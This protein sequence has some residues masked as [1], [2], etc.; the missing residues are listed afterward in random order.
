MVDFAERL[1]DLKAMHMANRIRAINMIGPQVEGLTFEGFPT[2]KENQDALQHVGAWAA[3]PDPPKKGL[4]IFGRPGSGKTGLMV[5]ALRC[6]AERKDGDA[7][8]WVLTAGGCTD[9]QVQ[10]QAEIFGLQH[11]G[12][13]RR[14]PAPVCADSWPLLERRLKMAMRCGTSHQLG[15]ENPTDIVLQDEIDQ[16]VEVY[17]LDDVTAS[18][19]SDWKQTILWNIVERPFRGKRVVLTF[20]TQPDS[21]RLFVG[22]TLAS[23]IAD[24]RCWKHVVING[25][26]LRPKVKAN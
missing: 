12:Q 21:L 13:L 4:A 6:C 8:R 24:A 22:E 25:S 20:A 7:E 14:R 16:N 3:V 23:R 17:G 15:D 26:S 18:P 2:T 19:A 9:Y 1:K 11:R 10:R 5:S